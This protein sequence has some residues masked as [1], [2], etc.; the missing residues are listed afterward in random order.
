MTAEITH[1]FLLP[2]LPGKPSCQQSRSEERP[3]IYIL[4]QC[5]KL[6]IVVR[7]CNGEA[8]AGGPLSI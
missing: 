6:G 3:Q 2:L 1:T 5:Q 8:E 7:T 4:K